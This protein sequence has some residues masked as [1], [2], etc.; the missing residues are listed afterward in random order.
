MN[1]MNLIQTDDDNK[2]I[3]EWQNIKIKKNKDAIFNHY[4]LDIPMPIEL[5][6]KE[7]RD[8]NLTGYELISKIKLES[9]NK[10]QMDG[11]HV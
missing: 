10:Q 8:S 6:E 4:K 5:D 9:S 7:N 2:G 3:F 1:E 11:T